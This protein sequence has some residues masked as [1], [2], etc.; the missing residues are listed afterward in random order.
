MCA[1]GTAHRTVPISAMKKYTIKN[2]TNDKEY[3]FLV[4][5]Y[6]DGKW[7]KYTERDIISATPHA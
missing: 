3:R 4:R 1:A 2:L 5:A 6:V 7:T